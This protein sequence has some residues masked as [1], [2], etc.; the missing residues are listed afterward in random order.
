[1]NHDTPW[2]LLGPDILHDGLQERRRWIGVLRK[3]LIDIQAM[4]DR[5][6]PVPSPQR[7][8]AFAGQGPTMRE[9]MLGA[10]TVM[11]TAT[12]TS[13]GTFPTTVDVSMPSARTRVK[14]THSFLRPVAPETKGSTTLRAFFDMAL[15]CLGPDDSKVVDELPA[16]VGAIWVLKA[17]EMHDRFRE[18]GRHDSSLPPGSYSVNIESET[19]LGH[20]GVMSVWTD[21]SRGPAGA[22]GMIPDEHAPIP[23]VGITVNFVGNYLDVHLQSAEMRVEGLDTM[24]RLRREMELRS[25][26]KDRDGREA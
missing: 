11:H 24:Q 2:L 15:G 19:P 16:H 10:G 25:I 17:L 8:Q 1:M 3:R 12:S 23:V 22:G 9:W 5:L 21:K 18:L 13:N 26:L 6:E 4:F 20:G 14:A 7:P